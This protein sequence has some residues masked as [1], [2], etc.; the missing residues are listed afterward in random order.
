MADYVVDRDLGVLLPGDI[1]ILGTT[2]AISNPNP[3]PTIIGGNNNSLFVRDKEGVPFPDLELGNGE[4]IPADQQTWGNEIVYQFELEFPALVSITS[5]SIVGDVD[6]FLLDGLATSVV[7][8]EGVDKVSA[9]NGI[10][11][12]LLDGIPPQ[13]VDFV[14]LRPGV[15]YLA[16]EN[17]DGV[18]GNLNPG[19]TNFDVTLT[20]LEAIDLDFTI[21]LGPIA[22]AGS[23][24]ELDTFGSGYNTELAIYDLFGTFLSENDDAG[25]GQQ[26]AIV[27]PDGLAAGTYYAVIA[28]HDTSFG[29]VF[30]ISGEGEVGDWTFNFPL[31]PVLDPG[32]ER[33]TTES[34]HPAVGIQFLQFSIAS[35]PLDS[36]D[37]GILANE[38]QPFFID[39][40][41]SGF[42]TQLAMFDGA[43]FWLAFNDDIDLDTNNL[44]SE[45]DFEEG[46]SA[47]T[48]FLVLAGWPHE[49]G[50]GFFVNSLGGA[51]GGGYELNHP[52]GAEDGV[53]NSNE[54]QW[55][56]FEVAALPRIEVTGLDFDPDTG[57][58]TVAWETS[59]PGPFTIRV[60]N[61]LDLQTNPDNI[62][63]FEVVPEATSPQS[64]V[65]PAALQGEP[66][67]FFQVTD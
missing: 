24:L 28:G 33:G 48:Y 46:L 12:A 42:D 1:T 6:F 10:D 34:S 58:F 60:G 38:N 53:L 23:P 49:Y 45:L 3:P 5:N 32:Q 44:Q 41:G 30:D 14:P 22:A 43:G 61:A 26:S 64:F 55:F 56:T 20:V 65:V 36:L 47:G 59:L 11:V 7:D 40:I 17:W 29:P 57:R 39:T 15:Y 63:P 21:D 66:E 35:P 16:A 13:T 18:D 8:V 50:D 19:N 31:G 2:R 27:L 54:Q 52:L 37:L 67:V 62:L 25:G 4:V 51:E 9:D